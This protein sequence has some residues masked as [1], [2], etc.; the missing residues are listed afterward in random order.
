MRAGTTLLGDGVGAGEI[1]SGESDGGTA[2]LGGGV[3]SRRIDEELIPVL[4]GG[5]VAGEP[6]GVVAPTPG[7]VGEDGE[8][9]VTAAG[10]YV[11]ILRVQAQCCGI[12]CEGC[13]ELVG[14]GAGFGV[15]PDQNIVGP[16][17]DL[18]CDLEIEINTSY[19][20]IIFCEPFPGCG[21]QHAERIGGSG[22]L[23]CQQSRPADRNT[24]VI[25]VAPGIDDSVGG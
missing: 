16:R 7:G 15:M 20:V 18:L 3:G 13:L 14:A 9:A 25:E 19:T 4:G 2:G 6:G 22:R 11:P 10:I 24:E 23:D 8:G 17:T 12:E 21:I 5:L 1:A